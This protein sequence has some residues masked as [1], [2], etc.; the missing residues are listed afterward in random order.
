MSSVSITV[1]DPGQYEQYRHWSSLASQGR[2]QRRCR[3]A[4]GLRGG[5]PRT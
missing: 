4:H 3:G 1:T 2:A 5:L